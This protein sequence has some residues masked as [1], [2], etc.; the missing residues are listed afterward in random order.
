M[1]ALSAVIFFVAQVGLLLG[2][3]MSPVH[4]VPMP[5]PSATSPASSSYW[6]AS[7]QRQGNVAFGSGGSY[8]VYRNVKDFGAKGQQNSLS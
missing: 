4:A 7:I 6:L 3:L 2:G 5:Q 8:K 1:A